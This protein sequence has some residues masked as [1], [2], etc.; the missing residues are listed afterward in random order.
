MNHQ[1]HLDGYQRVLEVQHLMKQNGGL[2]SQGML[3][4]VTG[5]SW[6]RI[7]WLAEHPGLRGELVLGQRMVSLQS[8]AEY[9]ERF[10]TRAECRKA[11]QIARATKV[12]GCQQ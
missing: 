6:Q 11:L 7:H 1:G 3:A 10:L 8:F 2:L 9:L 12:V 4:S 5:Y